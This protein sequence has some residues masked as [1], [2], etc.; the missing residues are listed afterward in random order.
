MPPPPPMKPSI[1]ARTQVCRGFELHPRQIFFEK[2]ES[3]PGCISLPCLLCRALLCLST[4]CSLLSQMSYFKACHEIMST[5]FQQLLTNL[6]SDIQRY[7]NGTLAIGNL[8]SI[9]VKAAS[10]Y[11]SSLLHV[12]PNPQHMIAKHISASE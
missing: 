5:G 12:K 3:C 4:L 7:Y 11:T 6:H 10:P 1:H 8:I 2:R 9:M